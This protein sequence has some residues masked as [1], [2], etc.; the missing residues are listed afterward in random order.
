MKQIPVIAASFL[1]ASGLILAQEPVTPA[2]LRP[3]PI[4]TTAQ[5]L[6]AETATSPKP[7]NPSDALGSGVLS[8]DY[9]LGPG[10]VLTLS[11]VS[12]QDAG[13]YF[14]DK[15]FRVDNSGDVTFPLAG[16]VH[17]AAM[18][19]AAVETEVN[20][21]LSKYLKDPH[22]VVGIAEFHS[23]PVSVL[24][25]VG[26]PGLI[27]ISGPKTIFEVL[28]LA[29]GL[30]ADAGNKITITRHVNEGEI[31]LPTDAADPSGEYYIATVK[32]KDVMS[33]SD[34]K[35]NVLV[36]PNDMIS[37]PK[38]EVVYAVGAVTKPGGFLL[39]ENGTLSVLQVLSLSEGLLK[40]SI[41]QR[42]SILRTVP[43][44]PGR[45]QI[46][47]NV[48]LML[49]GRSPDVP[50]LPEDILF[51]PNSTA[52]SFGYEAVTAALTT[53]SGLAIYGKF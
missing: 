4:P 50:L 20:E 17:V 41:P 35:E 11:E 1:C 22:V 23:Q 25:A 12:L 21:R 38:G 16:R 2:N 52:K 43:G 33:G 26:N 24:G 49:A 42:A 14:A 6:A 19:T 3:K 30:R 13:D 37:V 7:A 36:M 10:D 31:P 53:V 47:V 18:N 44:T 29:G 39:G 5:V 15:T 8:A 34:P 45:T 46:P 48:K 40:T 51:I 28:S 9:E 32:V 27:Q